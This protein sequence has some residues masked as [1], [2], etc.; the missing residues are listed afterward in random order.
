MVQVE[1][2]VVEHHFS[3]TKCAGLK[4]GWPTCQ[5]ETLS[6]ML[7][8]CPYWMVG[9]MVRRLDGWM[10]GWMDGRIEMVDW[11]DGWLGGWARGWRDGRVDG[12]KVGNGLKKNE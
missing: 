8:P 9:G 11:I 6:V 10:D 3:E 7:F 2:M 4:P 1:N 12:W 5:M